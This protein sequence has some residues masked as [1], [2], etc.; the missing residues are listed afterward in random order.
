[1]STFFQ[2]FNGAFFDRLC[3]SFGMNNIRLRHG[4]TEII[5]TPIVEFNGPRSTNEP[6]PMSQPEYTE[7]W[8]ATIPE[9][10][11]LA[12]FGNRSA[13]EEAIG[14]NQVWYATYP[15]CCEWMGCRTVGDPRRDRA[16]GRIEITLHGR[17]YD[18][19]AI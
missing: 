7:T 6:D 8:T 11:L 19:P 13:W 3:S 2:S 17:G 12:V 15:G 4:T 14:H 18:E 16:S 10:T 5:P 1:M 9:D